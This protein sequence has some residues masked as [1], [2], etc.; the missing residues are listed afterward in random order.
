[1]SGVRSNYILTGHNLDAINGPTVTGQGYL[2]ILFTNPLVST[3]VTVVVSGSIGTYG[4]DSLIRYQ[5][6]LFNTA[7]GYI[8]ILITYNNVFLNLNT[9]A[10]AGY[11][12]Y[13]HLAVGPNT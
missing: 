4:S 13:I 10:G 3:D 6:Y 7:L 5:G 9:D 1:M 2:R 12:G 11:E 8:D